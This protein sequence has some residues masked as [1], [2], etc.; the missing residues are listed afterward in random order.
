MN[1]KEI[2][3]RL[4]FWINYFDKHFAKGKYMTKEVKEAFDVLF[5]E[6]DLGNACS[7]KYD[8]A[9]EVVASVGKKIKMSCL[10]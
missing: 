5:V 6:I 9:F 3:E 2:I 1:R 10:N 7:K 4:Y 8:D